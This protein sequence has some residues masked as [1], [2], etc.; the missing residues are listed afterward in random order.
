MT[1]YKYSELYENLSDKSLF[2]DIDMS[3]KLWDT[4]SDR[5]Y[6]SYKNACIL[7][8]LKVCNKEIE[9]DQ[10]ALKIKLEDYGKVDTISLFHG[11]RTNL[12]E[13]IAKEGF[14]VTKNIKSA[15]GI[16]TYAAKKASYSFNYMDIDR[17]EISFMFIVDMLVG[18]KAVCKDKIN[19]SLYDNSVDNVKN[20]SI[21]VT[22]YNSGCIPKYVVAFHKNAK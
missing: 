16:G 14:D 9:N 4:I 1:G 22:P 13:K 15:Y 19:T 21:F 5:I 3:D 20:P 7:W 18:R 11:T 2:E 12:I 6:V 17:D 8:I 10:S